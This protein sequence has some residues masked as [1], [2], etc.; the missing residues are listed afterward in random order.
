[1]EE[2]RVE[3]MSDREFLQKLRRY[4]SQDVRDKRYRRSF[5]ELE[6][7]SSFDEGHFNE[8]D[9]K[10]IVSKMYHIENN[11]KYVGEKYDMFKAKEIIERYRGMLPHDITCADLY[12]AINSQYHDYAELFKTWFGDNTDNKVIES[13]IN[14]WFKDND[15]KD[16]CKVYK[17][18]TEIK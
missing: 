10:Y 14:F 3:N 2:L 1:M 8:S 5:D 6:E 18:F 17:Y 7:Y 9:A 4:F 12:V 11:R 13:A 16:G 15:W